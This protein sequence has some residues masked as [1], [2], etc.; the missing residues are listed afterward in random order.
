MSGKAKR[1]VWRRKRVL[2]ASGYDKTLICDELLLGHH[3]EHFV[4]LIMVSQRHIEY[5]CK[6]DPVDSLIAILT[7]GL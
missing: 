5:L 6:T 1:V 7:A 3:M 2:C 4:T